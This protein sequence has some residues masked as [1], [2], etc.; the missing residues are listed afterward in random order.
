MTPDRLK[1][2]K[3]HESARVSAQQPLMQYTVFKKFPIILLCSMC[4]Y[5]MTT[6]YI[7]M[8]ILEKKILHE[9]TE[10]DPLNLRSGSDWIRYLSES[11]QNFYHQILALDLGGK[12]QNKNSYMDFWE[13]SEIKGSGSLCSARVSML[14]TPLEILSSFAK[15]WPAVSLLCTL[16]LVL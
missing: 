6:I 5:Y 3:W 2:R 4:L 9:D 15:L 10:P 16:S 7:P 14:S 12:Y 8:Y 11:D 13:E 1:I